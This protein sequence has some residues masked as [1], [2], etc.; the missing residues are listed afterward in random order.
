MLTRMLRARRASIKRGSYWAE[1]EPSWPTRSSEKFT[2]STASITDG[3]SRPRESK[4]QREGQRERLVGVCDV[5]TYTTPTSACHSGPAKGLTRARQFDAFSRPLGQSLGSP[6]AAVRRLDMEE[7][8]R[9]H[10]YAR[11]SRSSARSDLLAASQDTSRGLFLRP[12]DAEGGNG[13]YCPDIS[14]TLERN[15]HSDSRHVFQA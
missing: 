2:T 3:A 1:P 5:R 15:A 6:A 13:K 12:Y 4:H 11:A 7:G 14:S 8:K 9:C 10:L